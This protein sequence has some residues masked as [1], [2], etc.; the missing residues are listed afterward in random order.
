[1]SLT[2]AA[3]MLAVCWV[4]CSLVAPVAAAPAPA[5]SSHGVGTAAGATAT[6]NAPTTGNATADATSTPDGSGRSPSILSA[7]PNPLTDGD[8]GEFVVVRTGGA[9]NLTLS[10]GE[11]NAS[12]PPDAGV[13]AVA[14]DPSRARNLTDRPVVAARLDLSNAGER[15]VLRRGGV[16]VGETT[17]GRAPDA[18]RWNATTERWVPRGLALREPVSAGP[19]NA[20]AFV[21]PDD[22]SVVR[23]TL[24]RADERIL[25]AGYT[26]SSTRV[27]DALVAAHRRGADVRVLV[28]GS[29]VGGV[30]TRQ[31]ETLTRLTRAGVAVRVVSGPRARFD[32]HHVKYAV[33]DGAALVST[34]NW[35]PTGTGG[36]KNRGWGVRVDDA[37]TAAE[38]ASVF[39]HDFGGADAAPWREY[40]RGRTFADSSPV[41]GDFPRRV[42]SESTAAESVAVGEVRVLTAPGN[43]GSAIVERFDG[44]ERGIDVLAPRVDPESRFFDALRRA[45]RRGVRV[46]ILLSNAWYDEEANAAL[47]NRTETLRE[48]GYDI[49]ARVARPDGRFG[50]VHAKGAVVDGERAFVG[51]LNWN[52]R[53]ATENR[54]VVLE[55]VG[56]GPASYYAA[57]F[58]AD[59]R[60]SEPGGGR[61]GKKTKTTAT[62]VVGA[63]CSLAL[64][65]WVTKKTVRFDA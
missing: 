53:A 21:L 11:S 8:T 16:V 4:L 17:Y 31:A 36:R 24:R 49:E 23:E 7:Y 22:P 15:L 62:L 2:R 41:E 52:D 40:R 32:Y 1:M 43:A 46:R 45:A 10:D 33:A 58:E 42:V 63:L 60:A 19:A 64:A 20:T 51:S 54:E 35:K 39:A 6:G 25:L 3:P 47:V 38:L 29:P 30:S 65:A 28:E 5:E 34:E 61:W 50:K 9:A 48:R 27:A 14:S 57:A 13:V 37:R 59:W 56:E 44:A 55:L 26:L 18:E 12:V